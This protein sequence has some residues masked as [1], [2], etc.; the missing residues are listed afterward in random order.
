[1]RR[2]LRLVL[3]LGI[4]VTLAVT[5]AASAQVVPNIKTD[6]PI[7]QVASEPTTGTRQNTDLAFWGNTLVQGDS[8]GIRVFDISE[9]NDPQLLSDFPCNGAYGDVSI[10]GNLV[11][12]SVD[13]PQDSAG[14]G[15]VD[16]T[17][18]ILQGGPGS[19]TPQKT[20]VAPGFEGIQIINIA[21]P[22]APTF[23]AGVAT[24]CGSH[25]N[26]LVPDLANN[27]V[28]L[29]VSSFPNVGL[30]AAPTGFGNTCQRDDP[31]TPELEHPS[32]SVVAVPLN[33]PSLAA[34]IN[35]ISL[36]LA[37]K[38]T[39][40]NYMP[41]YTG[42]FNN[43]PG[44]KGCHDIT[45]NLALNRAAAA[46]VS[47]GVLLNISNKAAPTIVDRYVNPMIDL[48]S[49]GVWR[50]G[51]AMNCMWSSAQFTADGKRVIFGSLQSG[52]TTCS[53]TSTTTT[54]S[55]NQGG[56]LNVGTDPLYHGVSVTNECDSGG[57]SGGYRDLPNQGALWMY[58]I[59]DSSWPISSFK[60]NRLERVD[61]QG[62]SS[63]QMNVVPVNGR[64]VVSAAWQLG[65]M[66][67]VDWTNH[68]NPTEI[69]YWDAD[70]TPANEQQQ[71][72]LTGFNGTTDSFRIRLNGNDSAVL[73]SGG[74][75][76]SNAN[77]AAAI[78]GIAGFAG[79][80]S[81]AGSGNG[82]FTVTFGG[83]SAGVN[84]PPIEIVE[85]SCAP[86]CTSMVTTLA[87][88]NGTAAQASNSEERGHAWA[89]YWYRDH[90]YVSYDTVAYSTFTPAGSRG[91][92][93]FRLD[94]PWASSAIDLPR[95]NP[96]TQEQLLRCS[97]SVAGTARAGRRTTVTVRVRAMGQPIAGARVNLKGP[98]VN[99]SK[100]TGA[101]GNAGFSVRPNR[102]TRL[103]A[104]IPAQVNMLGCSASKN[105]A[106]KARR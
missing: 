61:N 21:N 40:F 3:P 82:G 84:L 52:N 105:I 38:N 13:R 90:I 31:L 92:E 79:G 96:Q 35:E 66:D 6:G 15:S 24:D 93:V 12:R 60:I 51:E 9:P 20:D 7:T 5:G 23:V 8:R 46:C 11:F 73:G 34:V 86:T 88:G 33:N 102:S 43:E 19:G 58:N 80:A 26:T 45:V 62:C 1:M 104:T 2:L 47:E 106:R 101:N 27:R 71:A 98:G 53:G 69:A 67:V 14:C 28:L 78:N 87:E 74:S 75:A 65:G 41:G 25:A 83:A 18:T 91:L 10:W 36:P 16:T 17:A 64:Y 30:S 100:L 55:C 94:T 63:R 49:T 89:A 39:F 37:D 44:Y 103:N 48:C 97:A 85:L 95:L 70:T 59:A 57:G 42:V 50:A 99:Q 72:V 29:Y 81:A 54:T 56:F 32:I 22:A 4:L 68:L 77:V 76:I